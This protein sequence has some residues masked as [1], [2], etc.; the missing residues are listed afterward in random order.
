MTEERD[1]ESKRMPAGDMPHETITA[2]EPLAVGIVDMHENV[3]VA[4]DTE[5]GVWHDS[6]TLILART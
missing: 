5:F 4:F 3:F 6:I 2:V 1:G